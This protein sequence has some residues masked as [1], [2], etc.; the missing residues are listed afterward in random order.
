MGANNNNKE[1]FMAQQKEFNDFII[2][3]V[4]VAIA[5]PDDRKKSPYVII[6]YSAKGTRDY[7][8]TLLDFPKKNKLYTEKDILDAIK[9]AEGVKNVT[10]LDSAGRA[11]DIYFCRPDEGKITD[12]LVRDYENNSYVG[13]VSEIL[14]SRL[15]FSIDG[16][17]G[18]SWKSGRRIDVKISMASEDKYAPDTYEYAIVNAYNACLLGRVFEREELQIETKDK[19]RVRFEVRVGNS[20]FLKEDFLFINPVC[21]E[22]EGVVDYYLTEKFNY[23]DGSEVSVR[24]YKIVYTNRLS[25]YNI[26]RA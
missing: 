8:F 12:V 9:C 22:V 21:R 23:I 11:R 20:D 1:V 10:Y 14:K 5:E 26:I 25:D 24:Q 19:R 2:N 3:S 13:H 17:E 7:H 4:G 15:K 6:C 18:V 16:L